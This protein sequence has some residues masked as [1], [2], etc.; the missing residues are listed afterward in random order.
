MLSQLRWRPCSA[1]RRPIEAQEV[2]RAWR[3]DKA[4]LRVKSR[5]SPGSNP[6]ITQVNLAPFRSV[7]SL[8]GSLR[9]L[10]TN[11]RALRG[12]GWK[13]RPKPRARLWERGF[14]RRSPAA[15][16][17]RRQKTAKCQSARA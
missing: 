6:A 16:R 17:G 5:L 2:C 7:L 10:R 4:G 8:S 14:S 11:E 1:R 13:T 12:G 3:K 9:V 15:A